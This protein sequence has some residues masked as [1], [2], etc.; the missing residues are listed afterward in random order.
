MK[1]L[2]FFLSAVLVSV[3]LLSCH[4][5][6]MRS[7]Y[8]DE[9][10]YI[11]ATGVVTHIKYSDETDALYLAFDQ[12]DYPFS[13]NTFKIVGKNLKIVQ[14]NGIKAVLQM[15]DSVT[16]MAAPK[17]WGDG[18]VI[19]IVALIVDGDT[20]LNFEDGFDNCGVDA[21]IHA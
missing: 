14:E 8:A 20:L 19:P 10:N 16:F 18:Y 12:L 15:S 2:M 9:S 1:K 17:Y 5:S 3:C 11:T 13:D 4:S 21:N 6:K 7:Y